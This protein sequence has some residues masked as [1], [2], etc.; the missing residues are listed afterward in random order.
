MPI[1]IYRS[2]DAGAPVLSNVAGTLI[3]VLD[4]L[5]NGLGATPGAGWTKPF[6]GTQKAVYKQGPG[7][8]GFHFRVDDSTLTLARAVAYESMTSVDAGTNAFPTESQFSGGLYMPKSA[9]AAACSWVLIASEKYFILNVNQ[10]NE[11]TFSTAQAVYFGDF[12]S[13]KPGDIFNTI[14]IGGSTATIVSTSQFQ[15][16]TPNL[17]VTAGHYLARPH[18]QV[19]SSTQVCKVVNGSIGSSPMGG[20]S[21]N[22]AYPS[23]ITGGIELGRILVI[24][25]TGIRGYLDG[26]IT[27]LHNKPLTHGD[28]FTPTSGDFVGR[29]FMAIN[30]SGP[31]QVL[32][33]I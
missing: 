6:T 28:T 2:T 12:I 19:G 21:L 11:A 24:E 29:S 15:T 26:V 22:L 8:N 17:S 20:G 14:F 33:D 31:G 7:S 23:P 9:T 30:I 13:R 4:C 5:V 27:P 10:A 32:V 18:T 3:P 16:L 1:R 25:G